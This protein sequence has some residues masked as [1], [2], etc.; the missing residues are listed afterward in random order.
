MQEKKQ[1][2][3]LLT[4][5]KTYI[6]LKKNRV[7]MHKF[8]LPLYMWNCAQLL[9]INFTFLSNK[10]KEFSF[11]MFY[12]KWSYKTKS[13]V[14][15]CFIGLSNIMPSMIMPSNIMPYTQMPCK[16]LPK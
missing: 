6:S 10:Y 12:C 14:F 7:H 11:C 2:D 16:C 13:I 1:K 9:S 8:P 15:V 5:L 3:D 4:Y